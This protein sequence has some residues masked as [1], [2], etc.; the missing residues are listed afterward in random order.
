MLQRPAL[1]G[2]GLATA[3]VILSLTS[4]MIASAA[5]ARI[6]CS[7]CESVCPPVRRT[8]NSVMPGSLTL[9]LGAVGCLMSVADIGRRSG[10]SEALIR[11]LS[12]GQ[13]G[14]RSRWGSVYVL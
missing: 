10:P 6:H 12:D 1:R 14:G 5:R 2:I 9:A 13:S 3:F 4:R 8:V 11:V 7:T